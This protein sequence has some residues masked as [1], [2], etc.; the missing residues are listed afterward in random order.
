[1]LNSYLFG[2]ISYPFVSIIWS[3]VPIRLC[4]IRWHKNGAPLVNDTMIMK[5]PNF[6]L[7]IYPQ[8]RDRMPNIHGFGGDF[9]GLPIPTKSTSEDWVNTPEANSTAKH[10]HMEKSL[11][12]VFWGLGPPIYFWFCWVGQVP[13]KIVA[14]GCPQAPPISARGMT[15]RLW[16]RNVHNVFGKPWRCWWDGMVK[17]LGWDGMISYD[18]YVLF[19]WKWETSPWTRLGDGW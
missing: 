1:M 5:N 15:M 2:S 17:R 19:A 11:A 18:F 10:K 3:R 9:G 6:N 16:R 4:L 8:L 13:R 12:F 7:H 14:S